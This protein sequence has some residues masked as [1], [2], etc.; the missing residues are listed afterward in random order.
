MQRRGEGLARALITSFLEQAN[1]RGEALAILNTDLVGLYERFGFGVAATSSSMTLSGA[2]PARSSTAEVQ[3][4]SAAEAAKLLPGIFEATRHQRV[5]EVARTPQW[6]REH[7]DE[8]ARSRSPVEFAVLARADGASG[9]A[10]L[11]RSTGGGGSLVISELRASDDEGCRA[12]ISFVTSLESGAEVRLVDQPVDLA[13]DGLGAA[14]AI[15][16]GGPQPQLWLRIIDVVRAL[17][18]RRCVATSATVV[19]VRDDLLASNCG[20]FLLETYGDRPSSCQV[21]SERA[22]ITLAVGALARVFLGGTTFAELARAGE[23]QVDNDGTLSSL[24]RAFSLPR[25]PFCSTLL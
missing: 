18:L 23:V 17:E 16:S 12:L 24:D 4:V 20:R 2:P 15:E 8:A 14:G 13:L 25:A 1:R 5:G 6:W 7:L 19:E 22:E 3:F 9:Y 21:S 11:S 10:A